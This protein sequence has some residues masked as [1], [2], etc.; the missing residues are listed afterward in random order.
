MSPVLYQ[1]ML[2]GG[3]RNRQHVF[4][5]IYAGL[6]VF[7]V[8]IFLLGYLIALGGGANI[9]RLPSYTEFASFSRYTVEFLTAQHF[10]VLLLVT[11]TVAAGAITDEKSRGTLQYLLTADLQPGEILLGKMIGRSYQ[12][13]LLALTSLPLLAFFGVFAGLDLLGLLV[14]FAAT[15]LLI[16]ALAA[17]SLLASVLCR[18][19]RDAV[20]GLYS[21]ILGLYVL[22][23]VVHASLDL[24]HASGS[25][26]AGP[27]WLRGVAAVLVAF[28]PL[29]PSSAPIG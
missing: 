18:H 10:L 5:W 22:S 15:F 17:A 16:F 1:E 13:V 19:T 8:G 2:L 12:V 6:L 23:L 28:N 25:A 26:N 27:L 20:L 7:E 14:L 29:M 4:R 3:R 11:P 24:L 9:R 21:V